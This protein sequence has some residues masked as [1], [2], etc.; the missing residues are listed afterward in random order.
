MTLREARERTGMSQ[1]QVAKI[2]GISAAAVCMWETGRSVPRIP[3]LR[4]LTA[5]YGVS[6]DKLIEG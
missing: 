6:A 4:K 1:A 2:L 5:L 3:I